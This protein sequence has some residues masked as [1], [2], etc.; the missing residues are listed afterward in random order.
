M[1]H[2][3]IDL[4][5]AVTDVQRI[6]VLMEIAHALAGGDAVEGANLLLGAASVAAH[7]IRLDI[8]EAIETV[9]DNMQLCAEVEA[10]QPR[11]S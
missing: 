10:A 4:A 8:D 1:S 11:T 7:G 2:A 6:K 3:V 5:A 9:E